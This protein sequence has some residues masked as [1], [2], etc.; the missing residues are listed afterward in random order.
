MSRLLEAGTVL[1][2]QLHYTPSGTTRRDRS[3]VG[4]HFAS[5][6][7][8]WRP[9]CIVR[10]AGISN[11]TFEV[12]ARASAH[13]DTATGLVKRTMHITSLMPHMHLRGKAFRF[14][15]IA[16]DGTRTTLLDVPRYDFNWQL[17][18][19]LEEPIVLEAG[20]RI[21]LRAVF[22]NSSENLANPAPGRRGS[23]GSRN[24]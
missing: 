4:V 8:A 9:E 16:L 24:R 12:P 14:E 21:D 22:N 11:R 5:T 23:L 20:E 10:T 1:M 7:P 19:D 6:D 13:V 17:S 2:L 15:R 18:Y 3:A